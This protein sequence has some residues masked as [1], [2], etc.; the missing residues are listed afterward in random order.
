MGVWVCYW[1]GCRERLVD[2]VSLFVI[3]VTSLASGAC[4]HISLLFLGWRVISNDPVDAE[5]RSGFIDLVVKEVCLGS[6]LLGCVGGVEGVVRGFL[7]VVVL[8]LV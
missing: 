2:V 4:M 6:Q 8:V 7:R 3:I 5:L 1:R